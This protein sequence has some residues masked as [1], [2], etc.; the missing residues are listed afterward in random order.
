MERN[1]GASVVQGC[2]GALSSVQASVY[3]QIGVKSNM[4]EVVYIFESSAYLNS[5]IVL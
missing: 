5:V 2:I 4:C 3:P 1:S